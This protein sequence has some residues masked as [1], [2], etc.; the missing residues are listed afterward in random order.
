MGYH[1]IGTGRRLGRLR[2][3][4]RLGQDYDIGGNYDVDLL[5]PETTNPVTPSGCSTWDML[6]GN[7]TGDYSGCVQAN[8]AMIASV[9]ANAQAAGYPAPVIQAIQGTAAAQEALVP[10]DV[11]VAVASNAPVGPVNIPWYL[12]AIGGGVILLLVLKR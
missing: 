12:W 9:A 2:G 6:W 7:L 3:R 4:R 11:A 1:E 10:G 8:E 5:P